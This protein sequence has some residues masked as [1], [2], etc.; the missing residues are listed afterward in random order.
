MAVTAAQDRWLHARPLVF[1]T[2]PAAVEATVTQLED[3]GAEPAVVFD[4]ASAA[5]VLATQRPHLM[6]L[7]LGAEDTLTPDA[8]GFLEGVRQDLLRGAPATPL[9]VLAGPALASR[10]GAS[11]GPHVHVAPSADLQRVRR[12]LD[13]ARAESLG[14]AEPVEPVVPVVPVEPTA[15]PPP[16]APIARPNPWR[17]RLAAL[18]AAV[19]ALAVVALLGYGG[20]NLG[21]STAPRGATPGALGTTAPAAGSAAAATSGATV[22]G[23]VA[24]PAASTPNTGAGTAATAPA[25]VGI[26]ETTAAGTAQAV[27]TVGGAAP[28]PPTPEATAAAASPPAS[29]G[30][31]G[32]MPATAPAG[33]GTAQILPPRVA[34]PSYVA[35]PTPTFSLTPRPGAGFG[36]G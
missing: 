28:T 1:G 14:A 4:P 5:T 32:T 12:A 10:L 2:E 16:P 3:W 11:L 18:V 35:L 22:G 13:A 24:S 19:A 26:T 6:V 9:V 21:D 17:G 27:V 25:T 29:E 30:A 20:A 23:A 7:D 33:S 34:V 36:R 8:A 31:A 15:A